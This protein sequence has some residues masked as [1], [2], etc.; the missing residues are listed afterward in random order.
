[1]IPERFEASRKPAGLMAQH[2]AAVLSSELR[3]MQRW[4]SGGR[5][6]TQ[7]PTIAWRLMRRQNQ[8]PRPTETVR[9]IRSRRK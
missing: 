7:P 6:S 1:M 8:K 4:L 2:S 9:H 3:T 5:S